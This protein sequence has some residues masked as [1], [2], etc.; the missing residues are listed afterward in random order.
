MDVIRVVSDSPNAPENNSPDVF[1]QVNIQ[2][3]PSLLE[4]CA[5]TPVDQLKSVHADSYYIVTNLPDQFGA[6]GGFFS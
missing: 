2:N 1:Y 6:T 4:F 3:L 5:A